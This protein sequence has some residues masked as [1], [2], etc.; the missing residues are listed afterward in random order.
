MGGRSALVRLGKSDIWAY[1]IET[2]EGSRVRVSA[3]EW[4]TLGLH[5]GQRVPVRRTGRK[6][7]AMFLAEAAEEPPFVWITLLGGVKAVG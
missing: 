5:P 3:D 2:A 6:D 1:V 7:E 4:A